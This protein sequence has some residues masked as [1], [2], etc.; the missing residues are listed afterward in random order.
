MNE[1]LLIMT[2]NPN[3]FDSKEE[4]N[5]IKRIYNERLN[6]TRNLKSGEE[7]KESAI[8]KYKLLAKKD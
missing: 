6:R 3:Q 8:A 4:T 1:R 5:A 7:L 2:N